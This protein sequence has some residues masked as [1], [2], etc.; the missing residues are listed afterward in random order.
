[1]GSGE[2]VLVV[3]DNS[4]LRRM[5]A[6]QLESLGYRVLEAEDSDAALKVLETKPEIDLLLTD[7]VIT[8]G[9]NGIE[10][11]HVA[12]ELRPALKL[13]Y[14]SAYPGGTVGCGTPLDRGVLLLR[15]PFRRREIATAVKKALDAS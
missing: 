5:V 9:L 14:M 2:V 10:L 13:M 4:P 11:G 1:M 3:E 12:R 8:E 15:K 6:T 7:I